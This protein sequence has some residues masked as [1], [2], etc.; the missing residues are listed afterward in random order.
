MKP[1]ILI[2]LLLALVMLFTLAAPTLAGKPVKGDF[3][4][5]AGTSGYGRYSF[6]VTHNNEV[7][8]RCVIRDYEPNTELQ[9][10]LGV[11]IASVTVWLFLDN[12]STDA[13]GNLRYTTTKA[14]NTDYV[15]VN[16]R[17]LHDPYGGGDISF[18]GNE[19]T[20]TFN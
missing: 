1:K 8:I 9:V 15:K 4:R 19:Q 16:V 11:G 2:S 10:S 13:R 12:V 5:L 7:K 3:N 17:L 6:Q 14:I 18:I 20:L